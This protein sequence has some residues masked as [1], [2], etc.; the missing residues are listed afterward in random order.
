MVKR[1]VMLSANIP[2]FIGSAFSFYYFLG[3]HCPLKMK[4]ANADTRDYAS[5][6]SEY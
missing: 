4:I 3:F 6:K 2:R 1:S 5:H